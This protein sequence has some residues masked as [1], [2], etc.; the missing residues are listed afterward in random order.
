MHPFSWKKPEHGITFSNMSATNREQTA[1][2]W[3]LTISR[4]T[5]EPHA[6]QKL[7]RTIELITRAQQR[8]RLRGDNTMVVQLRERLDLVYELLDQL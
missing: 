1:A 5:I 6:E 4:A 3:D 7:I 8:G 2:E